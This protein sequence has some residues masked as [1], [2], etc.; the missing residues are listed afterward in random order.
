MKCIAAVV[1]WPTVQLCAAFLFGLV[2]VTEFIF[3]Y[4]NTL[5]FTILFMRS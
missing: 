2:L 1:E 5:T 4:T 3:V